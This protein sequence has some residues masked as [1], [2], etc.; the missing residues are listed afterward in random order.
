MQPGTA[1]WE[2]LEAS[3]ER[4]ARQPATKMLRGGKERGEEGR[5]R[6]GYLAPWGQ[7]RRRGGWGTEREWEGRGGNRTGKER[8]RGGVGIE[9]KSEEYEE[10]RKRKREEEDQ[11]PLLACRG[12]MNANHDPEAARSTCCFPVQIAYNFYCHG[13][14]SS[15]MEAPAY[16]APRFASRQTVFHAFCCPLLFTLLPSISTFSPPPP[17]LNLPSWWSSRS[18]EGIR[19]SHAI[20]LRFSFTRRNRLQGEKRGKER[21]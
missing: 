12:L 20:L 3:R 4:R 2:S 5:R 16:L 7:R 9:G 8:E 17:S 21:G 19:P 13:R 15:L 14:N 10:R 6:M 11:P 18:F 1:G